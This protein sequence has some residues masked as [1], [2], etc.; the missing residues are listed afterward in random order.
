MSDG[1][2]TMGDNNHNMAF[3]PRDFIH[4]DDH[5]PTGL[6]GTP[7]TSDPTRFG[8]S[9]DTAVGELAPVATYNEPTSVEYTAG[10]DATINLANPATVAAEQNSP[11]TVSDLVSAQMN[12][13]QMAATQL[14]PIASMQMTSR[15]LAKTIPKPDRPI[16]KNADGSK[17]ICTFNGCNDKIREW[18][19]KCE[20]SKHMD[21]HDRPY[22]CQNPGCEKLPGF[23]YSGGLLR[24]EREVHKKHGGP[25]K[26]YFCKHTNCKRHTGSGF[27]RLEN[28][29]EHLRRV[30][31][32][33]VASPENGADLDD[34]DDVLSAAP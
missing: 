10:A 7:T 19:R 13:A 24:H 11:S 26:K 34:D 25:K 16:T 27:S 3:E 4:D 29:N 9:S 23:T 5:Y 32:E 14:D 18:T 15:Q 28:L 1:G 8:D 33:G 17:F 2:H 30:H 12:S 6:S 22:K 31:T 20:W 21:K